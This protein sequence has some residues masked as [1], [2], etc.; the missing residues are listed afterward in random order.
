MLT[1]PPN[2]HR[3]EQASF[4]FLTRQAD[5]IR[6]LLTNQ[7]NCG[8]ELCESINQLL[9]SSLLHLEYFAHSTSP[10]HL[11]DETFIEGLLDLSF[12]MMNAPLQ[13]EH[14]QVLQQ[15]LAGYLP[16]QIQPSLT[17]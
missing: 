8:A 12:Q 3:D 10:E 9:G 14:R 11:L 15:L 4:C 16:T 5:K 6:Q 17:I 13:T 7:E 2:G 1:L